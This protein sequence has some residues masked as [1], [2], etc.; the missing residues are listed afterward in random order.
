MC[1]S[2]LCMLFTAC[3]N[4]SDV[5]ETTE[6][7]YDSSETLDFETIAPTDPPTTKHVVQITKDNVEKYF[8]ISAKYKTSETTNGMDGDYKRTTL[9]IT[10]SAVAKKSFEKMSDVQITLGLK[11][12]DY[13][14][15]YGEHNYED[16]MTINVNP[17]S[18]NGIGSFEQYSELADTSYWPV[19]TLTEYY[20][21]SASGTIVLE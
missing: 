6:E 12:N 7:Y 14:G 2:M 3:G 15:D 4:N 11:L 10:G 20:I 9:Y 8:K 13:K 21:K 17:N 5:E 1:L 19:F 16:Q 18:G